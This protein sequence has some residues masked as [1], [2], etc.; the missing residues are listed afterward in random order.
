M[1]LQYRDTKNFTISVDRAQH[2]R[3]H[4][5]IAVVSY[6]VFFRSQKTQM[7]NEII[8]MSREKIIYLNRSAALQLKKKDSNNVNTKILKILLKRQKKFCKN[9][10]PRLF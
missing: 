1:A 7:S 3:S 6:H 9:V 5:H 8:C 2:R 4:L 10:H